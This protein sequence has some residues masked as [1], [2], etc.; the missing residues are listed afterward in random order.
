M[1]KIKQGRRV[2]EASWR[3]GG[4]RW[5]QSCNLKQKAEIGFIEKT[6]EQIYNGGGGIIVWI[7][8]KYSE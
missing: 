3:R 8:G 5:L 6:F 4:V 1:E 2:A 7:S